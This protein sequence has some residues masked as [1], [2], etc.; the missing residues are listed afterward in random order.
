MD[1]S[2][3]FEYGQGYVALS[4]VRSLEGLY[5]LGWNRRA[6]EVHPEVLAKDEQ[7]RIASEEAS[8]AFDKIPADELQKMHNNFLTAC[9][10]SLDAVAPAK[11]A[12]AGA[13]AVAPKSTGERLA[14]LREQHP[15]AYK[16]WSEDD[17][18]K[19]KE[20]FEGGSTPA[21]SKKPLAAKEAPSTQ[22]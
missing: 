17:D 14:K 5:L 9:G 20:M 19:L 12:L 3:V 15:N 7:F 16:P 10:G 8:V 2:Q 4:R 1:L 13:G 6:F 21:N 22:D 18:D 11:A